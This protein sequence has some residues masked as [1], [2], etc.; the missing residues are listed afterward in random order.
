ML[1]ELETRFEELK[2]KKTL[3]GFETIEKE[4]LKHRIEDIRSKKEALER[5][6]SAKVVLENEANDHLSLNKL[7]VLF[8]SEI[9]AIKTQQEEKRKTIVQLDHSLKY[10]GTS[11]VLAFDGHFLSGQ[12]SNNET[13]LNKGITFKSSALS[14]SSTRSFS[15]KFIQ[16]PLR[17]ET[18]AEDLEDYLDELR[19]EMK[20][21]EKETEREED[22]LEQ[23][24]FK[25]RQL[26]S[27]LTL[28]KRRSAHIRVQLDSINH[29]FK[30]VKS[31]GF[32]ARSKF[33][34]SF[35]FLPLSQDV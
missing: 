22:V 32:I 5:E 25:K 16:I 9:N 19:K 33:V 35:E 4:E 20:K 10:S 24:D 21:V 18:G 3:S 11:A 34:N 23:I 8:E 29:M 7:K 30:D 13:R 14:R 12:P 27:S 17:E 1:L 26:E 6:Y 15:K 31:T 28:I 2:G